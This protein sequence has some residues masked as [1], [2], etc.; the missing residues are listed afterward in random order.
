MKS[1]KFLAEKGVRR[2][3]LGWRGDIKDHHHDL[4]HWGQTQAGSH[5]QR[6]VLHIVDGPARRRRQFGTFLDSR[7]HLADSPAI[8]RRSDDHVPS[9]H[10][11]QE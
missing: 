5:E 8:P 10:D 11:D 6:P 9:S 3:D 4:Q 7:T 1:P 2:E